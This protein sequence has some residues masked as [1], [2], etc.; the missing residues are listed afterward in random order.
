MT[1]NIDP[2]ELALIEIEKRKAP[3]TVMGTLAPFFKYI[4]KVIP[5]HKTW[6]EPFGGPCEVL[7][8]KEHSV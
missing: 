1:H 6:V 2:L 5:D 7:F 8:E 3:I 4:L